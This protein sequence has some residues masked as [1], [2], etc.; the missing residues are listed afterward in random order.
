MTELKQMEN[1]VEVVGFLKEKDLKKVEMNT[2]LKD[3]SVVKQNVIRGSVVIEFTDAE[4][5]I[6]NIRS[7]V[8]VGDT[9][10]DGEFNKMYKTY[11][12]IFNEYIPREGQDENG[13]PV[14]NENPDFVRLTGQIGS[15]DYIS[16]QGVQISNNRIT[17]RFLNRLKDNNVEGHAWA[18]IQAYVDGFVDEMNS[19]S[20]PTGRKKATVFTVG[21]GGRVHELQDVFV[22]KSLADDFE[23]VYYPGSTGEITLSIKHFATIEEVKEDNSQLGFGEVKEV[24][25]VTNYTDEL[26]LTGGKI[27]FDEPKALDEE[28]I[29]LLKKT[30]KETLASLDS[31]VP[32]S[33]KP[34]QGFGAPAKTE[35]N[36][37]SSPFKTDIPDKVA[38]NPDEMKF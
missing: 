15:N 32:S 33:A 37:D 10:R 7:Q 4:G 13:N 28:Q 24:K 5:N 14:I 8:F 30:R 6:N 21:Y 18:T 25:A 11:D 20:E 19:E 35:S 12:T 36:S 2:T 38:T 27:P 3:K 26:W 9:K 16:A 29:A 17:T 31:N 22:P 23:Q 34:T 1:N